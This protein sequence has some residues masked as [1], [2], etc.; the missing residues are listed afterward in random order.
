MAGSF[1]FV[2]V[3]VRPQGARNG[4]IFA[5][6]VDLN[7][8]YECRGTILIVLVICPGVETWSKPPGAVSRYKAPADTI[9]NSRYRIFGSGQMRVSGCPVH[10]KLSRKKDPRKNRDKFINT[11]VRV[12]KSSLLIF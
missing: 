4:A 9:N 2:T 10:D 12:S 1:V 6:M 5:I 8:D 11:T 7:A 3:P